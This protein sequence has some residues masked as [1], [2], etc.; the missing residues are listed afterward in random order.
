M[1]TVTT[2]LRIGTLGA[3][4][5]APAALLK[6]SRQVAGVTVT[7]VAA[8]DRVR[9]EKFAAKHGIGRVHDSYE[10][11]LA[12]PDVDAIYNPL[13]NGLHGL[14]TQRALAAGKHVLCEKPFT[15]NADEAEKVAAAAAAANLVVME[16]FHWRYHPLAKRM[17]EVVDSGVLGAVRRIH[18]WVCFPLPVPGDIRYRLDLA[19]G[20]TMDAGCYA[21]NMVRMLAGAEPKV[22]S[23]RA[24]LSSP[25][26]DRAMTA[27]LAFEDGR[28]ARIQASMFSIRLLYVAARVVGDDGRLDVLNPLAPQVFNR[29]A[30]RTGGTRTS[31]RV[32]GDATYTYQ[33]QAFV[34]AVRKSGPILTS[35]AESVA[36]MR[37]IDD[38]YRAAGLAPRTPTAV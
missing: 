1:A 30:I 8:R 25:G 12:D 3:A 24:K 38:V 4:K 27:E 19:G 23:A 32:R 17:I 21:I 36:N 29:L 35:P 5:I 2:S 14:W 10:A 33:L 16:A 11:L 7:A 18:T 26:V 13:P 15:A 6:P 9:A 28:T 22:L 20:A 31:E 37:V 34:D